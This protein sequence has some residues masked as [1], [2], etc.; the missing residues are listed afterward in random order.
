MPQFRYQAL[1]A[2]N[3]PLAGEI[4][5]DSVAHA[6]VQLEA[7][8]LTVQSIG[9]AA[10]DRVSI[11]PASTKIHSPTIS[12]AERAEMESRLKHIVERTRTL[13]PALTALAAE[14]PRSPSRSQLL[15]LMQTAQSGDV[16][17]A[18]AALERKP[19]CWIPLLGSAS[20]SSD[21]CH[22]L[23]AIVRE[24]QPPP[25]S[26]RPGRGWL[27][28]PIIILSCAAVVFWFIGTIVVPGF[29]DLFAGF[30]LKL[31]GL[32]QFILSFY[33]ALAN[34]T[35]LA[36]LAAIAIVFV[37]S[38]AFAYRTGNSAG[39]RSTQPLRRRMAIA[40]FSRSLAE[41]VE[42]GFEPAAALRLAGAAV[43]NPRLQQAALR[44]AGQINAANERTAVADRRSITSS[45]LSAMRADLPPH[46]KAALLREISQCHIERSKSAWALSSGALEP[47]AILIVG[48]LI[49]L[50]VIG[51]YLPLFSLMHSLT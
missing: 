2:D 24:Y 34:G 8:G 4:L 30:G 41:L 7:S 19:A 17:Q 43:A 42:C 3:Q 9:F 13:A 39:G 27:I 28:Y 36:L 10:G 6:I 12:A 47:I 16:A 14:L 35:L 5:A 46:A 51:L 45:V 26:A 31:P 15:D 32:T 22:L 1:N 23:Q 50:T 20:S 48:F 11:P 25:D 29:R 44:T 21:L 18:A 38:R 33:A 49:A 40:M 37:L